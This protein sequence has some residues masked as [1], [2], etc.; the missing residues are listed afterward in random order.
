MAVSPRA[1]LARRDFQ[2]LY[3]LR[4]RIELGDFG[5]PVYRAVS[6]GD[7]ALEILY[8]GAVPGLAVQVIDGFMQ[9]RQRVGVGEFEADG[10]K[11]VEEQ[12]AEIGEKSGLARL[13]AVARGELE[14]LAKDVI[15]RGGGAKVF[16][17]DEEIVGKVF[18]F[19][20]LQARM[21][22]TERFVVPGA[23][24]A[25]AASG[26]GCV[27]AI[28]VSVAFAG[29]GGLSGGRRLRCWRFD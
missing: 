7:L 3:G 27:Q 10:G 4:V 5:D 11:T 21:V 19:T 20:L 8:G 1:I 12:L 22:G 28:V 13:N 14:D 9:T 24:H 15:D 29:H 17:A 23:E 6:L 18:C 16:D 25:A 26:G 2:R